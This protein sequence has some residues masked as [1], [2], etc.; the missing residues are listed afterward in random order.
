MTVNGRQTVF[1]VKGTK[2]VATEIKTGGK[3]GDMVE[4][5]GGV[6]AGDK[7]ALKPLDKLKDGSKIKTAEK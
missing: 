5:L 2:V 3:I 4:V 1:L 6:K 7:V